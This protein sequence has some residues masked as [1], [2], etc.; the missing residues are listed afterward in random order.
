M[1]PEAEL[2][3]AVDTLTQ[4]QDRYDAEHSD[5]GSTGRSDGGSGDGLNFPEED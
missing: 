5:G 1:N 4:I 3:V 2:V